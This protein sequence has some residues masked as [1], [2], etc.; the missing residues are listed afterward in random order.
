MTRAEQLVRVQV[1][2]DGAQALKE[3]RVDGLVLIAQHKRVVGVGGHAAKAEEDQRFQRADV[4]VGLP[5]GLQVVVIPK[6]WLPAFDDLL[7]IGG[8]RA[9]AVGVKADVGDGGE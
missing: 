8:Q 3:E 9:D 1:V 4:L 5:E 2:A 6:R 7:R